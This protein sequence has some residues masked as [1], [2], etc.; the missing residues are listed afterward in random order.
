MLQV[1]VTQTD[2][3]TCSLHQL[4]Q[5]ELEY[6]HR[7]SLL[8]H[9]REE[10][11]LDVSQA[12]HTVIFGCERILELLSSPCQ[13][14]ALRN[15]YSVL[16][17]VSLLCLL[18][19]LYVYIKIKETEKLQGKIIMAN[20]VA[21][22]F[23]NLYFLV[24]YNE[25]SIGWVP[26]MLLGYFGYFSNLV[27]FSWMSVMLYNLIRSFIKLSFSSGSQKKKFL[28]YS[29]F[30]LGLPLLLTLTAAILQVSHSLKQTEKSIL[31]LYRR[32]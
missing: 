24:V 5:S 8:A 22:L 2:V 4:E 10:L 27:M 12:G 31:R 6:L 20:V 3:K 25:R 19:T 11:C 28:S 21:T 32:V 7:S 30:A 13:W 17:V 14:E 15:V 23:V 1:Q 26:C 29:S 18:A 9:T 16:G